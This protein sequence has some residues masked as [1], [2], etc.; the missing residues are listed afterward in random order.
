MVIKIDAHR[1]QPELIERTAAILKKGGVIAYPTETFYAL[2]V[3]SSNDQ[4]IARIFEV[5]GRSFQSP[6]ALIAGNEI[7]LSQIT[8]QVPDSARRLMSAFWPGP[9]TLVFRAMG[10]TSS[11]LTAGTGKIGVRIS[12]HAVAQALAF[13][14]GVPIT[15][16]SA[17]RSGQRECITAEDVANEIGSHLDIILDGGPT[18]GGQGSTF[19]DVTQD[20][21]RVLRE[22]AISR[23]D[24]SL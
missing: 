13:G 18:P 6:I 3:D 11:L 19:L 12:S 22:G 23:K 17:N 15:A 20:P 8:D 1:P 9:L 5:K 14:L 4:A 16:T 21:P 24:L 7:Q 10:T 2:G